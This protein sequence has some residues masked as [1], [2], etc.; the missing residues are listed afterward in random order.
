MAIWIILF[1]IS[2]N[3][4]IFVLS[5]IHYDIAYNSS[6][7]SSYLCHS[8]PLYNHSIIPIPTI[9]PPNSIQINCDTSPQFLSEILSKMQQA[10]PNPDFIVI[11][12]DN[13]AHFTIN[14][15]QE[16]GLFN[17]SYNIQKVKES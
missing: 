11:L 16:D 7:N 3:G 4:K 12:G 10:D 17:K 13:I 15:T 14:L 1:A 8:K 5:D 2:A 6:Y 9:D